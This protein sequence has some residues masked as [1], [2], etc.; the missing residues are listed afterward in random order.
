[1]PSGWD[2]AVAG[3]RV[4]GVRLAT[5]PANLAY[6]DSTRPEQSPY[7]AIPANSPLVYELRL[8]SVIKPNQ[9]PNQPNGSLIRAATSNRAPADWDK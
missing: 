6:G 7:P 1:M 3:M 4:G 9:L 8:I 5:L 2:L